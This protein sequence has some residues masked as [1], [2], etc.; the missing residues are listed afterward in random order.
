[1]N[2]WK[3]YLTT[4]APGILGTKV[5]SPESGVMSLDCS[6]LYL[7]Y[8]Y[9]IILFVAIMGLLYW[10]ISRYVKE[11]RKAYRILFGRSAGNSFAE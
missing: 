9:G 11:N 7:L 1:M 10:T 5:Y 2:I 3:Y 8:Y 6:Y 4:F